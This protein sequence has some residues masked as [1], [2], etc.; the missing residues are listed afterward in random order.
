[1]RPI[2][3]HARTTHT[4]ETLAEQLRGLPG[5]MLLGSGGELTNQARYSFVV[6]Q[7]F[8]TLRTWG[9]R[10]ETRAA[11]RTAIPVSYTHL[12]LPTICSV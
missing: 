6:A 3:E 12:T 9:S 2:I 4:A 1:M 7:P 11:G 5:L 10:C 8:L